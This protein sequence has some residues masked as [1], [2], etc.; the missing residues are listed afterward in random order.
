MLCTFFDILNW[1]N[2][3]F[4][5]SLYSLSRQQKLVPYVVKPLCDALS[6]G[7]YR[8]LIHYT[9]EMPVPNRIKKSKVNS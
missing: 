9:I 4:Q 1:E 2:L 6:L 5:T 8:P 7:T 3:G